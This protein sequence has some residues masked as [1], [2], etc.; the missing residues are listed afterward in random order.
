MTIDGR[1]T[2]IRGLTLQDDVIDWPDPRTVTAADSRVPSR[3]ES[4]ALDTGVRTRVAELAP[5]DRAGLLS[6]EPWTWRDSGRQYAYS[7][8]RLLSTLYV[9]TPSR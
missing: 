6:V 3:V 7:Y 2:P 1:T 5:V 8:S 4:V 9:A